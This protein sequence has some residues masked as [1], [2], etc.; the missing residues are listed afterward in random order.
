MPTASIDTSSIG[1]R[2]RPHS[3]R[4]LFWAFTWLALQGFG[5]VL[6]VV[7]RELVDRRRWMTNEEFME[8]WAAAQILPGPNVVNLSIMVG[9]RHFGAR[10]ALVAV[11]GMLLLPM[12]LVVAVAAVYAVFAT[13][14]M[15]VG[16]L[17]G[18]GAVAA[19]LVAGVGWPAGGVAGQAP[20]GAP[21][22]RP[23]RRGHLCHHERATPAA[24]LGAAR[25]GRCG[26]RA[27]V[28]Q[29][30]SLIMATA[31]N[32]QPVD[33]LNLFLYYLSI[34]LLPWAAPSPRRRTC[35]ASWSSARAGS[36]TCS[37]T[38]PSSSPS[39]RPARTCCSSPC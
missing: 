38:P 24:G 39:P 23:D 20:A 27:H 2:P 30:P 5:G 19:G 18:M 1:E 12:L 16:A 22:L 37:S 13:H 3:L 11:V 17:R 29:A 10:G 21:A 9:D 36:P 33:W 15:V 6:A 14:P 32:L 31:L 35:T 25:G 28:A 26:L 8:D 7:Q 34:S 4:E